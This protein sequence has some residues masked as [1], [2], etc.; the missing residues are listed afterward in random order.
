MIPMLLRRKNK[1]FA[2]KAER[3]PPCSSALIFSKFMWVCVIFQ[4][5]RSMYVCRQLR[6]I[7]VWECGTSSARCGQM[8]HSGCG[9]WGTDKVCIS[10]QLKPH[11]N[12]KAT[13]AVISLSLY[14]CLSFLI[15]SPTFFS[16]FWASLFPGLPQVHSV[17]FMLSKLC[18]C[19]S[20]KCLYKKSLT[21]WDIVREGVVNSLQNV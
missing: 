11:W 3:A 15:L 16:T 8:E 4:A 18:C 1:S 7:C 19:V 20:T 17:I 5:C 9:Y 10:L 13:H 2:E 6:G 14:L 12:S 21:D